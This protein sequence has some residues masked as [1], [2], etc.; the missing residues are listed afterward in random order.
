MEITSFSR[1]P[2]ARATTLRSWGCWPSLVCWCFSGRVLGVL[3]EEKLR[4]KRWLVDWYKKN[5]FNTWSEPSLIRSECFSRP[6]GFTWLWLKDD[7]WCVLSFSRFEFR[8]DTQKGFISCKRW[9]VIGKNPV[10]QVRI[11]FDNQRGLNHTNA[12]PSPA[13]SEGFLSPYLFLGSAFVS[14]DGSNQW[15]QVTAILEY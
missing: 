7:P 6:D 1:N 3:F 14:K 15:L 5:Y 4:K 2:F 11:V 13:P 10:R 9:S 12:L 8:F